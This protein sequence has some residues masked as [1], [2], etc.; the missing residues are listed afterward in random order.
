MKQKMSNRTLRRILIPIMAVILV[1]TVIANIGMNAFA[2]VMDDYLGRGEMRHFTAEGS[3]NWDTQYYEDLYANMEESKAASYILAAQVQE[4][5]SVLLKN[6]G[7]LPL[8]KGSEVTPFG[9]R[10]LSPI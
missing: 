1:I 2:S 4:E 3:E 9:Y 7:I 8:A 6:N 5:G 10:Y